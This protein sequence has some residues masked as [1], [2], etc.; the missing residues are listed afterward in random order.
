MRPVEVVAEIAKGAGEGGGPFGMAPAALMAA[1]LYLVKACD[2]VSNSYNVIENLFAELAEFSTRLEEYVKG[3]LG[4][5]MKNKIV[6]TLSCMLEIM[7]RSEEL[8]Q[9]KR[10]KHFIG[11][12]WLGKDD[13]TRALLERLNTLITSEERLVVAVTY[14]TVQKTDQAAERIEMTT[15]ETKQGVQRLNT[16]VQEGNQLSHQIDGKVDHLT[17]TVEKSKENEKIDKALNCPA[18]NTNRETFAE[19]HESILKGTGEWLTDEPLFR[20]WRSGDNAPLLFV[21]GGPGSGKTY[22][23]TKTVLLLREQYNQ[24][25]DNPSRDAVSY[26][27]IKNCNQ[28]MHDLN[29]LLK[30]VAHQIGQKDCIFMKHVASVC[31]DPDANIHAPEGTWKTLF[32]DFYTSPL[33]AKSSAF[34]VI[35]GLDEAPNDTRRKLLKLLGTLYRGPAAEG[36]RP[37]LQ[38]AIFG[39]PDLKDDMEYRDEKVV[40]VS[41]A[42]NFTDIKNYI[43]SRLPMVRVLKLLKPGPR[44]AF[45]REIL[46]TILN[47]SDGMFFWAKLVLDQIYNKERKSEVQQAL[48]KAPKELDKMIR[49]IFERI[50]AD[51]DVNIED[52]NKILTWVATARRPLLLGEV[53]VILK[54]RTGEPNLSLKSRLE[55]KFAS[56]FNLAVI[57]HESYVAKAENEKALARAE[58]FAN[59]A[60]VAEEE[61]L[62]FSNLS[63]DDDDYEEGE[64]E[65]DE[66]AAPA[67]VDDEFEL[68]EKTK[69]LFRNMD[70]T[71]SHKRIKDYL[72]QEGG[73]EALFVPPEYP[74]LPIGINVDDAE[75]DIV[76]T[77]LDDV[78]LDGTTANEVCNLMVYAIDN[79]PKHL[80][81]LNLERL[82]DEQKKHLTKSLIRL[83]NTE[84]GLRNLVP[85]RQSE[86]WKAVDME[87]MFFQDWLKRDNTYSKR[88]RDILE[89]GRDL[90][91]DDLSEADKD[92]LI[93]SIDSAKVL[94]KP[95]A[96]QAARLWL[97]KGGYD[98]PEWLNQT[99]LYFWIL[100]GYTSLNLDGTHQVGDP[101]LSVFKNFEQKVPSQVIYKCAKWAQLPHTSAWHAAV[102]TVLLECDYYAYA[103]TEFRRALKADKKAWIAMEGLAR[104]SEGFKDYDSALKWMSEA[105]KNVPEG[106]DVSGRFALRMGRSLSNAGRHEEAADMWQNAWDYDKYNVNTL[107]DYVLSLHRLDRH[108]DLV[109]LMVKA[110]KV[111]SGHN[112]YES[113]LVGLIALINQTVYDA[114]GVAMNKLGADEAKKIFIEACYTTIRE[115]DTC[116][117]SRKVPLDLWIRYDIAKFMWRF[118]EMPSAAIDMWHEVLDLL[119]SECGDKGLTSGN[120]S[121]LNE[122]RN[123]LCEAELQAAIDAHN[124]GRDPSEFVDS[125]EAMAKTKT[126]GEELKSDLLAEYS[127]GITSMMYGVWLRDY[128]KAPEDVWRRCF[129][130]TII[131]NCDLLDDDDPSN[132]HY[133]YS[134]LGKSLLRADDVENGLAAVS[135]ASWPLQ[136]AADFKKK[137]EE[138]KQREIEKR[139]ASNLALY[140]KD[141]DIPDDE[142]EDEKADNKEPEPTSDA[143]ADV[144]ADVVADLKSDGS[145]SPT[146]EASETTAESPP[147]PASPPTV[148]AP[149][150][151]SWGQSRTCDGFC[152]TDKFDYKELY[153]CYICDADF[154]EKCYPTF[155]SGE[156]IY[157]CCDVKHKHYKLFPVE[158]GVRERA[159]RRVGDRVEPRKEFLDEIRSFWGKY[160]GQKEVGE[161]K[162]VA[163]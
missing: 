161:V 126:D 105:K 9:K 79:W 15:E 149:L 26:F 34:I 58:S 53:H 140:G 130:P 134:L 82:N 28:E 13:K 74:K 47:R 72:V 54:L 41:A 135:V 157:R 139:K 146:P 64:D 29:A 160:A 116:F 125:L 23:A 36:K 114:I 45:A 8:I 70:V 50:A 153:T 52:L 151:A 103:A 44:K 155:K 20:S 12:A 133:A 85:Y 43:T 124:A 19:L 147:T 48:D 128:A 67:K 123:W 37:R 39:R 86:S 83:F 40:L 57:K 81:S 89:L 119:Q 66:A 3:N 120:R 56:F 7:G 88:V 87:M 104:C 95:M 106:V 122:T 17:E 25:P 156:M 112:C 145:S 113:V 121:L 110:A 61:E 73:D 152:K 51:P 55:G 62:D 97:C 100:H 14:S 93:G 18:I 76:L 2:E 159:A 138:E 42:K 111:P 69:Y 136:A 129:G 80:M 90:V 30:T 21:F 35:D 27:F 65:E 31:N 16:D 68:D 98:D 78:L 143:S 142:P 158:E 117:K 22:L 118:C 162:V 49:H 33:G 94:F 60:T 137:K 11:V 84:H 46:N 154:C 96:D 1:A 101:D 127:A 102:G 75:L 4:K 63:D 5:S 107:T 99:R 150:F 115:V 109:D 144:A 10:F 131:K 32:L 24:D 91:V 141:I 71:F 132:D 148:A 163:S 59:E 92:W 38:V 77:L 108:Q 6:G